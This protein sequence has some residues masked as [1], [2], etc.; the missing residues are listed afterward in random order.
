MLFFI[1]LL[2]CEELFILIMLKIYTISEIKDLLLCSDNTKVLVDIVWQENQ[3]QYFGIKLITKNEDFFLGHFPDYSILPGVIQIE[4]ALQVAIISFRKLLDPY[5]KM[6]IYL[7]SVEK[8]KFRK[9]I[10][11]GDILKVELNI[12]NI[13]REKDIIELNV[14]NYANNLCCGNANMIISARTKEYYKFNYSDIPLITKDNENISI[15][16]DE[17]LNYIPHRYPF[18]LIDYIKNIEHF[19]TAEGIVNKIIAIK[20]ITY[21]D[22]IIFSYSL[23]NNYVLSGL[24][25]CEI[26]AQAGCVYE[27]S[28]SKNLGKLAIFMTIIRAEFYYPIIP[29]DQLRLEIEFLEKDSKFGRGVG[30]AYVGDTLVSRGEITFII[31]KK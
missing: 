28:K 10:L 27:L 9:P 21:N 19:S 12:V 13:I 17:I 29:G 22:P 18:I 11:P 25:Q 15:K 24:I 3:N 23:P 16:H 2:I 5:N 4:I 6:D 1:Y 8:V 7:K 31:T 20:N 30:M 26:M 14:I